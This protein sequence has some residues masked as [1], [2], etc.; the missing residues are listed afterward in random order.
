[1]STDPP[2][3]RLE[4]WVRFVCGALFGTALA[5][6]LVWR[7]LPDAAFTWVAFPA[8]AVLLGFAAAFWGDRFWE[9]LLNMF[10]WY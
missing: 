4:F 2:R 7:F 3:D 5:V 10:R 6:M 9:A 1:M 8:G